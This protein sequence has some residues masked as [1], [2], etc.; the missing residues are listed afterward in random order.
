MMRGVDGGRFVIL[1]TLYL[2]VLEE[3]R[4]ETGIYKEAMAEIL[5]QLMTLKEKQWDASL[6]IQIMMD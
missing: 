1:E 5:G 6:H 2:V 4:T 3:K